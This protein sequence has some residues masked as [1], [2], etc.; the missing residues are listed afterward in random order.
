[1]KIKK[2]FYILLA[3]VILIFCCVVAFAD[4]IEINLLE[5]NIKNSHNSGVYTKLSD[6]NLNDRF[7]VSNDNLKNVLQEK[8]YYLDDINITL[9]K[10]IETS[11]MYDM[12]DIENAYI[13]KLFE[14]DYDFESV[15]EIYQ[16]LK[17]TDKDISCI[18]EIYDIAYPDFEGDTWI[19]NAYDIYLGDEKCVL[20]PDDISKYV[21]EGIS[22]DEILMCYELSLSNSKT[23]KQILDERVSGKSWESIVIP[24]ISVARATEG[25][26]LETITTAF[27][28][29][30]QT[31][32]ELSSAM[33][34]DE[35][36]K[37]I[38]KRDVM[39]KFINKKQRIKSLKEK[40]G[41]VAYDDDSILKEAKKHINGINEDKI[42]NLIS[43]GY[44]IKEIKE[45][46]AGND[47]IESKE[48]M[49]IINETEEK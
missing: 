46:V 18:R 45:A 43:D 30:R 11:I 28:I 13:M 34:C 40:H 38:V 41:I 39:E 17:S 24:D 26:S 8:G 2:T 35:K 49:R 3:F 14:M 31:G 20:S 33:D 10:Y 5:W 25:A 4:E 15:I 22:I 47:S 1:M 27:K 48:I 9:D 32:I 42:K 29:S 12:T 23:I 21:N 16:F 19:Q 44:R 37:V 7:L 6:E 36:G